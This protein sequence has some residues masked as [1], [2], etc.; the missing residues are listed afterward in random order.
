MNLD[1]DIS[2]NQ[3]FGICVCCGG[4]VTNEIRFVGNNNYL[5]NFGC[6]EERMHG[7]VCKW[8]CNNTCQN[9][10]NCEKINAL[11]NSK[12]EQEETIFSKM[13]EYLKANKQILFLLKPDL[14]VSVNLFNKLVQLSIDSYVYCQIDQA[15]L[16]E[17]RVLLQ[18]WNYNEEKHQVF[19]LSYCG[20]S[21]KRLIFTR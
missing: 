4:K 20:N 13:L 18:L 12:K 16:E 19:Q 2:L 14:D 17:R 7:A 6:I 21:R 11:N 9:K 5:F 15:M 10:F 1:K 3:T 8:V